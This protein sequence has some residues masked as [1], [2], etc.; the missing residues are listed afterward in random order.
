[1]FQ[2]Y[3][4]SYMSRTA[5]FSGEN[6]DMVHRLFIPYLHVRYVLLA[7][8]ILPIDLPELHAPP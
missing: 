3:E 2:F 8:V 7:Y 5:L 6:R 1:M 4:C